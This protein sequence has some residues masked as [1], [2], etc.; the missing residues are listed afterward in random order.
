MLNNYR[1]R[2]NTARNE[3]MDWQHDF[4]NH[5]YSLSELLEWFNHFEKIG[6]RYGLLQEFR[7]NGIC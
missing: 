5:D 7:D 3:A 6:R 4:N 2:Q 1:I